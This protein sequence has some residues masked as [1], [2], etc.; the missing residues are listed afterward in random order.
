MLGAVG[1]R[2]ELFPPCPASGGSVSPPS[3][4]ISQ[5]LSPTGGKG[6]GDPDVWC[7]GGGGEQ[8]PG[9]PSPPGEVCATAH[10]EGTPHQYPQF[11]PVH[12][13][14]HPP[15]PSSVAPGIP[16]LP[17]Q[18]P[19]TPPVSSSVP[20]LDP[21][22]PTVPK[23]L[24]VHSSPPPLFPMVFPNPSQFVPVLPST[25]YCIPV[26]L[27]VPQVPFKPCPSIPQCLPM[28]PCPSQ[29]SSRV[30]LQHSQC[31]P[32]CSS[33]PQCLPMHPSH[34]QCPPSVPSSLPRVPQ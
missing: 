15:V 1:G 21:V 33:N 31:L 27:S 17:V 30:P 22:Y 11:L 23:F 26:S 12:A 29:C 32:V 18:H 2:G 14:T 4:N 13:S 10:L 5:C 20:Q 25:S 28:H 9:H 7:L 16:S 19:A 6:G 8:V 24:S 34:T 3:V